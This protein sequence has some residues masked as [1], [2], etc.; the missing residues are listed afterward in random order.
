MPDVFFY[1]LFMDRALL[2]EKGFRPMNERHARVEDHSLQ[3]GKRATLVHTEKSV[4]HGIVMTLSQPEIEA[5]YSEPAVCDYQ[6]TLLTAV[7]SDETMTS[8]L[9]YCLPETAKDEERNPDYADK[10]RALAHQLGLPADYVE[11]I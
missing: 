7:L 11:S 8:A 2:V 3:I 5:L 4:V 1:G 6:P 10:L 9:C